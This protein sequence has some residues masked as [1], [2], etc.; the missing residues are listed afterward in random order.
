ME[1]VRETTVKRREGIGDRGLLDKRQGYQN[2]KDL[3]VF[4]SQYVIHAK[5]TKNRT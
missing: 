5:K 4:L 1:G 2:T 3:E